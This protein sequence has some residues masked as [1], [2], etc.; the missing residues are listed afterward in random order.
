MFRKIL[1]ISYHPIGLYKT[2]FNGISFKIIRYLSEMKILNV[3]EKNDAAKNIAF[4]LAERAPLKVSFPEK[5]KF[6][7]IFEF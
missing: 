6:I 5:K 3:A 4:Y 7:F 2:R 1:S